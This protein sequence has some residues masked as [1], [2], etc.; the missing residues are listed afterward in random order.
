MPLFHFRTGLKL[1]SWISPSWYIKNIRA[2][3]HLCY[4]RTVGH[5]TLSLNKGYCPLNISLPFSKH[6]DVGRTE[7][8]DQQKWNL[9]LL[10]YSHHAWN[11]YLVLLS[12]LLPFTAVAQRMST[13]AVSSMH[14]LPGNGALSSRDQG[15]QSQLLL[16][17]PAPALAEKHRALHRDLLS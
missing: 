12:F 5:W 7:Y 2:H 10:P 8:R 9:Y 6:R 13:Q 1:K 14:T 16:S 3:G 17:V 15:L 4:P 11:F